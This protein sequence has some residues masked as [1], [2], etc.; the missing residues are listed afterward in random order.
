MAPIKF[1]IRRAARQKKS[2]RLRALRKPR[3]APLNMSAALKTRER[4]RA[5][6]LGRVACRLATRRGQRSSKH[7]R[8][9]GARLRALVDA[10]ARRRL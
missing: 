7:A 1:A 8:T 9:H 2:P 4:K 3:L 6:G 5:R 10:L